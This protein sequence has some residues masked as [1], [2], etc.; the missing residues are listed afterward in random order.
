MGLIKRKKF[1][2]LFVV[3]PGCFEVGLLEEV[4]PIYKKNYLVIINT[5]MEYVRSESQFIKKVES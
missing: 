3:F 5:R 1:R 4:I 2:H